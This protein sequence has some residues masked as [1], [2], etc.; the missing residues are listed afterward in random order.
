MLITGLGM[1]CIAAAYIY[2]PAGSAGLETKCLAEA[3]T[4]AACLVFFC[5]SVLL[6][7]KWPFSSV[8]LCERNQMLGLFVLVLLGGQ[9]LNSAAAGSMR[10]LSY[11]NNLQDSRSRGNT[12]RASFY[13]KGPPPRSS[14]SLH[15]IIRLRGGGADGSALN[16]PDGQI[17]LSGMR[18]YSSR[19]QSLAYQDVALSEVAAEIKA[20]EAKIEEVE[21][22]IKKISKRVD[23]CEDPEEKKQLQDEKNKLRDEKKQLRD[24]KNK[25]R[26]EKNK[27]LDKKNIILVQKYRQAEQHRGSVSATA[28]DASDGEI[29]L[30][31]DKYL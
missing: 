6:A 16:S 18:P 22:E 7:I 28:G 25:L 30:T 13:A 5:M 24:E 19:H 20:V 10:T 14:S 29:D 11:S 17:S 8:R 23:E 4:D 12:D 31:C 15:T 21:A 26:D 1:F 2:I 27:L 3:L 9:R